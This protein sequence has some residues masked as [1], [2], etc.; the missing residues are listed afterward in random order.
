[1]TALV[2]ITALAIG[3]VLGGGIGMVVSALVVAWYSLSLE[4]RVDR[5]AG[6][7]FTQMSEAE[8]CRLCGKK[9]VF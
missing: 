1:M 9:H 2:R 8:S 3:F 5:K 6:L 7:V 4:A